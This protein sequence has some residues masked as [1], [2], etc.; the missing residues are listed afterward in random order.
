MITAGIIQW[1]IR[2]VVL[3][4]ISLIGMILHFNYHVSK[5]FYGIDVVRPGATGEISAM[6]HVMKTVYYH[7]PMMFIV[8]LLFLKQRWFLLGITA[9]SGVYT[10]SHIAHVVD[11]ITKPKLDWSQIPL[12]SLVLIFSVILNWASWRYYQEQ[13][14][15]TKEKSK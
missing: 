15:E 4:L 10:I 8:T 1:Q 7:F 9:I 13:A 14:S 6:A 12:L 11:E 5:I 2:V 3:W